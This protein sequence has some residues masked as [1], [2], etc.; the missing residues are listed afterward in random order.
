MVYLYT[1]FINKNTFQRCEIGKTTSYPVSSLW[2][3]EQSEKEI[4]RGGESANK[5]REMMPAMMMHLP[6]TS[7]VTMGPTIP[8][9]LP[10]TSPV[11]M[12]HTR[13][14]IPNLGPAIAG[15]LQHEEEVEEDQM[16]YFHNHQ[17]EIND[18]AGNKPFSDN[19][20]DSSPI[21]IPIESS[22][23]ESSPIDSSEESH[24]IGG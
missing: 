8:V 11:T 18:H 9:Y 21:D 2:D 1:M 6:I 23:I 22:P 19:P 24:P 7:P 10:I 14:A 16:V 12:G 20:I 3:C 17:E 4:G 5:K 15:L 13:P